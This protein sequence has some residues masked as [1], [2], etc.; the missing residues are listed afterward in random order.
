MATAAWSI[1]IFLLERQLEQQI[2]VGGHITA[3][4]WSTASG[5]HVAGGMI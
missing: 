3:G 2:L 5:M 4:G 1:A